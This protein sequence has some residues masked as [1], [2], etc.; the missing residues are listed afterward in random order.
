[1]IFLGGARFAH[2][3]GTARKKRRYC[4]AGA[5]EAFEPDE[6]MAEQA[7][8]LRVTPRRVLEEFARI[9]FAD[10][11]RFADGGLAGVVLKAP[12][13]LTEADA[14]AISEITTVGAGSSRFRVK[15]CD[16]KA[17]LY[18]IAR[19]LGKFEASAATRRRYTAGSRGGCA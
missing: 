13:D 17:A 11:H 9:A 3:C 18:A 10:L 5:A 12:D 16:K 1:M 14:A 15:L 2:Y 7:A 19:H 8:R 6:E 4:R